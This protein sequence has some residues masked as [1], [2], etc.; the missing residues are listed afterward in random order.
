[1]YGQTRYD[2][3]GGGARHIGHNI[4]IQKW[5][6]MPSNFGTFEVV[7]LI[8]LSFGLL[9]GS[10]GKLVKR[11]LSKMQTNSIPKVSDDMTK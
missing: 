2:T 9:A 10:I 3:K 1:M 4:I 7:P 8:H 11:E 5:S 6:F